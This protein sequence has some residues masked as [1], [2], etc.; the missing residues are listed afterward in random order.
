MS[1]AEARA[2]GDGA[3]R[4]ATAPA[5]KPLWVQELNRNLQ[6]HKR[7]PTSKYMQLA[8][9]TADGDVSCRWVVFRGFLEALSGEHEFE[10]H[11]ML[12]MITDLRSTKCTEIASNRR[13]EVCVYFRDTRE[14]LR[15][16]GVL[17]LIDKSETDAQWARARTVQWKQISDGARQAFFG[18]HPGLP[19]HGFEGAD[20]DDGGDGDAQRGDSAQHDGGTQDK[21][22]GGVEKKQDLETPADDFCLL[23][24]QPYRVDHLFLK[25]QPQRRFVHVRNTGFDASIRASDAAAAVEVPR[26]VDTVAPTE[27]IVEQVI[28]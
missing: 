16:K 9:A 13:A 6:K 10:P 23:V 26:Q 2:S 22:E 25:G 14:Q 15:F 27:W 8:T 1:S 20:A 4:A 11:H 12:K 28:A 18:P 19:I 21:A 5:T 3:E 7:D 17:K 24:L